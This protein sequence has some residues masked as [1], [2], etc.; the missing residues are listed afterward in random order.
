MSVNLTD[1]P[2][3]TTHGTIQFSL[4]HPDAKVPT[5]GTA[6]SNAFDLYAAAIIE[7]ADYRNKVFCD[8]GV[9]VAIPEGFVGLVFPRSSIYKSGLRLSN[10]VGVIDSDYRGSIKAVFDRVEALKPEFE[11]GDRICQ[12][13]IVPSPTFDLE[14]VVT[15]PETARGHGSFGS[16]G[17]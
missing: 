7:N 12:L 6:G 3:T 1:R 4:L 15:L 5:K 2:M 11:P 14:Q 8:T 16:T 13:L 10:A 17:A 9:A